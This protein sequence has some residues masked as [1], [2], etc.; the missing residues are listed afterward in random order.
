VVFSMGFN[1]TCAIPSGSPPNIFQINQGVPA[2]GVS[3]V[4]AGELTLKSG[5]QETFR[6]MFPTAGRNR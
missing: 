3:A 5:L 1:Y 6:T 4:N 2:K